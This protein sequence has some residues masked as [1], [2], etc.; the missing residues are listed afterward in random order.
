MEKPRAWSMI[1]GTLLGAAF[2]VSCDVCSPFVSIESGGVMM[3]VLATDL[4]VTLAQDRPGTLAQAIDAI[5]KAGINVEGYAEMGGVLHVLTADIAA[6]RRA[7]DSAGFEVLEEHGVIVAPVEDRPGSAASVF[8]KIADA[9]I[10]L[11]YSYLATGNRLVIGADNLH[12]AFKT[13]AD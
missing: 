4:I 12:G 6:A 8:Q 11:R 5:G 9:G 2:D 3:A 1:S 7:L 13:L 10:N